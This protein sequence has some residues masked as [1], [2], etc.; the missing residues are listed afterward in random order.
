V[1]PSINKFCPR[2][3]KPVAPNSLTTYKSHTIGFRNSGGRDH[4]AH[5]RSNNAGDTRYFDIVI[6]RLKL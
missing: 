4:F 2:S 6:K 1:T 3:G 5:D